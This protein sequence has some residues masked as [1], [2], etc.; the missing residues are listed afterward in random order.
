MECVQK[1][2]HSRL[3]KPGR[4]LRVTGRLLKVS[5]EKNPVMELKE[6][7]G[8]KSLK[9]SRVGWIQWGYLTYP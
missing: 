1:R 9:K 4:I 7:A 5:I 2:L 6:I 3:R 8:V